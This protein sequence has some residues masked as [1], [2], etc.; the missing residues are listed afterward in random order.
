MLP[1][2]KAEDDERDA[3]SNHASDPRGEAQDSESVSRDSLDT[4]GAIPLS[5][6]RDSTLKHQSGFSTVSQAKEESFE[7]LTSVT[8]REKQKIKSHL[9][10][11][12]PYKWL[13]KPSD[14]T[15]EVTI[16]LSACLGQVLH[17]V[18]DMRQRR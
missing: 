8:T 17:R 4:T 6:A 14:D 3:S 12:S 5:S 11:K 9:M 15:G 18:D 7:K 13:E 16:E 2:L 1:A 10:H